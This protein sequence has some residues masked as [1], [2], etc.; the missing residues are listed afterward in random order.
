MVDHPKLKPIAPLSATEVERLLHLDV[1]AHLATIDPSG[2]PR[3]TPIWFHLIIS[4]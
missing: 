2:F 3:I 1:A 4:S